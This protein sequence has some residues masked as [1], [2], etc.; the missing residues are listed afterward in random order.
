M[1]PEMVAILGVGIAG[2]GVGASLAA[3]I[4]SGQ[5]SLTERMLTGQKTLSD[6][7]EAGHKA[8]SDRMEAG[9]KALSDRMDRIEDTIQ[10]LSDRVSR[11][12]GAFQLLLTQLTGSP[13][14]PEPAARSDR[15]RRSQRQRVTPALK[16]AGGMAPD[17]AE[18]E[19]P[20]AGPMP[21]RHT[22]DRPASWTV[23]S[24]NLIL[25]CAPEAGRLPV[26]TLDRKLSRLA[27][28]TRV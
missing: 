3:L 13:D 21:P 2:L 1:N 25:E 22:R 14:L 7:M 10:A 9:H 27:G 17:L 16:P 6:R 28:A 26:V 8:L 11:L 18:W 12:E 5:R 24:W 20:L 19:A 23:S 15:T 4:L